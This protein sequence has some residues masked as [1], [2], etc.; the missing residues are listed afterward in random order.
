MSGRRIE[1]LH[2]ADCPNWKATGELVTGVLNEL[3]AGN[4]PIEY[5]LLTTPEE[6]AAVPFSGSPTV[7]ID[8][9][10]EFLSEGGHCGSG[11][12]RV[13]HGRV[14]RRGIIQRGL[15]RG[16]RSGACEHRQQQ[17]RLGD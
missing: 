6:A 16:T 8:G 13:P 4:T 12:P 1:I 14:L 17:I 15:A 9:V 11:V 3:G 10:D 2:I 7:L 5:V